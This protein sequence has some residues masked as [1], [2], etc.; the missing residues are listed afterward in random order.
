MLHRRTS[1][2]LFQPP[3]DEPKLVTLI[4]FFGLEFSVCKID[5]VGT[6]GLAVSIWT[7]FAFPFRVASEVQT[8]S[9]EFLDR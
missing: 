9:F 2:C 1:H 6:D 3:V 5:S 7:S 8:P 4:D